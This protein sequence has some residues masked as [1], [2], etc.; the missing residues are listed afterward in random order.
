M[1]I[2]I[3]DT[4][5]D[6][7]ECDLD[8]D[9]TIGML[10]AEFFQDRKWPEEDNRGRGQRAVVELVHTTGP[11]GSSKAI[12]LK[13]DQTLVDAE[14]QESA[15]LRIFPESIAGAVD[16]ALRHE[17]LV[18]D[19]REV[20]SLCE[21]DDCLDY[22]VLDDDYAPNEYTIFMYY[23]SFS[24]KP[25]YPGECPE[26]SDEHEISIKLIAD[27]PAVPPVV[28]WNT[29]I[30]HPNIHPQERRVCL[31]RL[32]DQYVPSMGLGKLILMLV[33]IVQ[34]R[35]FGI[36]SPYDPEAALWARNPRNWVF[37]TKIGGYPL[38]L[39]WQKMIDPE[40]WGNTNRPSHFAGKQQP[41][42]LRLEW[43]RKKH[44]P[45]LEFKKSS[46]SG[47]RTD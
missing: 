1:K 47:A 9:I 40:Y 5:G 17:R 8:P 7:F 39:P 34:W 2:F 45:K 37:I 42:Y 11:A 26:I 6:R 23:E 14:V 22:E 3:E 13:P 15:T 25:K 46:K 30:F 27:Y 31:G 36:D 41:E 10:A 19:L 18:S 35:N 29:D 12:R 44:R 38:P 20:K 43:E 33:D 21:T 4:A 24:K 28:R 16:S 32:Q